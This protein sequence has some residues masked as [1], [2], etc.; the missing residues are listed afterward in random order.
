MDKNKKILIIEDDANL[1][2]GLQ[3]KF[4]VEGFEVI[5]DQGG[6]KKEAMEKIKVLRPDYIIL[7]VILPEM[8]GFDM[9]SDIK[10]DPEISKI[11]VF[12]FTNL[13]DNDSQQ[14]GKDLGADFYIIKNE[15]NLDEFVAKFQKIIKNKEKLNE[16]Y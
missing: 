7:D 4:R 5:I 3:S 2:Y 9:L 13:S 16:N 8:N 11:P 1:L 12:I 10:A 6:D 15:L 14:R